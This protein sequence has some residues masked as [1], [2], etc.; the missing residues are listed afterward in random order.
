MASNYQ[1]QIRSYADRLTTVAD[2][3]AQIDLMLDDAALTG[4]QKTVLKTY[5]KNQ[6]Q[7]IATDLQNAIN[8]IS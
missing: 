8:A 1:G 7:T 6:L 3:V 2:L 4:P 5:F